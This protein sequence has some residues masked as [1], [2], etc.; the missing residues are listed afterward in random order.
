MTARRPDAGRPRRT[1]RG[2]GTADAAGR[3][4]PAL[5][6]TLRRARCRTRRR[7][8]RQG[9]RPGAAG[10]TRLRAPRVTTSRLV[11]RS[12]SVGSVRGPGTQP[13]VMRC[14]PDRPR[15]PRRIGSTRRCQPRRFLE[16]CG[17]RRSLERCARRRR[18]ERCG[19]RRGLERCARRR[20]REVPLRRP[21]GARAAPAR[22]SRRSPQAGR[23]TTPGAAHPVPGAH[24]VSSECWRRRDLARPGTRPRL[25]GFVRDWRPALRPDRSRRGRHRRNRSVQPGS[26]G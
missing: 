22:D 25:G 10:P 7:A 3:H 20:R 17:R 18:L 21:R 8:P 9:R 26:G 16:P 24:A 12:P 23:S 1:R 2:T 13:A 19:R 5:R 4:C 14:A 6:S 15:A 11:D